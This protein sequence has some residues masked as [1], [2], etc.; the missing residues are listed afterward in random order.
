MTNF[1]TQKTAS[2]QGPGAQ[3]PLIQ[4][5]RGKVDPG[6]SFWP[7][8]QTRHEFPNRAILDG[9]GTRFRTYWLPFRT[10]PFKIRRL[11]YPPPCPQ[12]TKWS[13]RM[14]ENCPIGFLKGRRIRRPLFALGPFLRGDWQT[15]LAAEFAHLLKCQAHFGPE[16]PLG[17]LE[18]S[19]NDPGTRCH[20]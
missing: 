1:K 13:V 6:A 14:P 18:R 12:G 11:L 3:T 20:S 7:I 10:S 9:V 16:T 8:G 19:S 2:K 17:S 5:R 15:K 4:T